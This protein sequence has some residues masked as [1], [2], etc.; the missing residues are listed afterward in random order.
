M[1]TYH[2]T[3]TIRSL[4]AIVALLPGLYLMST[5]EAQLYVT[6]NSGV[7]N[8]Y[9]ANTGATVAF[10]LVSG[11]A[12]TA[13]VAVS[14]GDLYV[15]NLNGPVSEWD[16]GT[17][18]LISGSLIS[19]AGSYPLLGGIA[20]SGTALYVTDWMGPSYSGSNGAMFGIYNSSTGAT[21]RAMGTMRTGTFG[22][23]A[24]SG[25]YVFVTTVTGEGIR[26]FTQVTPSSSGVLQTNVT[27]TSLTNAIDLAASGSNL[28]VAQSNGI[29]GEYN[30][31]GSVVNASLLSGFTGI[32][33]IAL[34]GTN[35]YVA[36]SNGTIGE[37]TTGGGTVNAR[38][39]TGVTGINDI[40]VAQSVPEPSSWAYMIGGFGI[41]GLRFRRRIG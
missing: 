20:V 35:L 23:I 7:I 3:R 10:S 24:V 37:Y 5:A 2:L 8:E 11:L 13:G 38:L 4:I 19:T 28:F 30:F 18:A 32:T 1:K 14:G 6:T 21:L 26:V 25:T 36:T 22:Q 9:D 40:S 15:A 17:G 34:S 29:I 39:V 41:L 12:S 33:G 27:L 31:D 16:A